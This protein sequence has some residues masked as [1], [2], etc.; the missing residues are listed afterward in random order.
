MTETKIEQKKESSDEV[1]IPVKWLIVG[2]VLVLVILFFAFDGLGKL[3]ISGAAVSTDKAETNLLNFFEEQVPG[4]NVQIISS[5]KQESF[6]EI[7]VDM[8]GEEFPLYITLDGK[9]LVMD[10]IPLE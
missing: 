6:Y 9:F 3:G 4:S 5:S 10:M 2:A 7:W 1:N 8:D